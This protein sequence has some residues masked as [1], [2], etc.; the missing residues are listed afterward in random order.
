[1]NLKIV[2]AVF[3]I[4]LM[5]IGIAIGIAYIITPTNNVEQDSWTVSSFTA[6]GTILIDTSP[7]ENTWF[8]QNISMPKGDGN[9]AHIGTGYVSVNIYSEPGSYSTFNLKE[10]ESN[11]YY[12]QLHL[13]RRGSPVEVQ[14]NYYLLNGE[15]FAQFPKTK[16]NNNHVILTIDSQNLVNVSV[17]GLQIISERYDNMSHEMQ[18]IYTSG[19]ASIGN[20]IISNERTN[21]LE[22]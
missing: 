5:A 1:M 6:E 14:S 12:F 22:S 19:S 17:N 11:K 16:G 4:V 3:A 2:L 10:R 15:T 13:N 8:V 18:L 21:F 20:T 7:S 9:P